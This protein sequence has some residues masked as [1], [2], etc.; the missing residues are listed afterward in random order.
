MEPASRSRR[1]GRGAL[2]RSWSGVLL[3]VAAL[4][5]SPVALAQ[6][7]DPAAAD[8]LFRKGR[9]S[10]EKGDWAGACPK[11]TESQ[12]LD[13]APGTLLNLADCE[14]HLGAFASAY[15]H[16]KTALET[17]PA[18]DDRV[19][20]ARQRLAALEKRVPHLTLNAAPGLPA[21]A[22]VMR[23]DVAL[24]S[25]SFGLALPV[26]P[27]AHRILVKAPG[28]E[29][30]SFTIELR[31]GDAL[32]VLVAAGEADRRSDVAAASGGASS[33]A[34]LGR[35]RSTDRAPDNAA[36]GSGVTRGVSVALLGLGAAGIVTGGVTGALVLSDKS[37]VSDPSHCNQITHACDQRG[38][39]AASAGRVLSPVSTAAFAVGG[40][41]LVGGV[42]LFFV[43]ARGSSQQATMVSPVLVTGGAGLQIVQPF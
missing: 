2:A 38:V 19:P 5:V 27:G 31:P 33:S 3:A 28:H 36:S 12:R 26:D 13:P 16:F 25:A 23:D 35:R 7:S 14:E 32:T 9:E 6:A 11:F 42:V 39:D 4:G 8:A 17:L 21:A 37:V 41:A 20:F 18:G 10:A 29:D 24:G 30:R 1:Q 34:E 22:K 40:A 43:S 15:E